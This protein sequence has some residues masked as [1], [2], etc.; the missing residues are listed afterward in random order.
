MFIF[1]QKE[2]TAIIKQMLLFD[3]NNEENFEFSNVMRKNILSMILEY[4]SLHS[5]NLKNL[6]SR[7]ILTAI[8]S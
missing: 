7:E 5:Y 2:E 6:K 3:F 1:L 4:Y 8:F